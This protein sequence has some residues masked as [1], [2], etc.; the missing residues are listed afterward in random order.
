LPRHPDAL[1]ARVEFETVIFA[2]EMIALEVAEREREE[3]VW[4][5]VFE[6][7]NHAIHLAV[8]DDGFAA[9]GARE[10]SVLDLGIPG[11]GVPEISQK[12][13]LLLFRLLFTGRSSVLQCETT[14]HIETQ[15]HFNYNAGRV[16]GNPFLPPARRGA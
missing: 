6:G 9:D 8:E 3:A 4:A 16:K 2:D 10:R 14:F 15:L 11:D 13:G 1:A 7:G 5:A 12:H